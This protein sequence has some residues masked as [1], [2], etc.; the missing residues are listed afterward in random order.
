MKSNSL[1]EVCFAEYQVGLLSFLISTRS[2]VLRL[3]FSPFDLRNA[4]WRTD[5]RYGFRRA[6]LTRLMR[7]GFSGFCKNTVFGKRRSLTGIA[8]PFL[9]LCCIW[10]YR[11]V[12]PIQSIE[13]GSEP[14]VL[15]PV[16][17]KWLRE[18]SL[19]LFASR[20]LGSLLLGFRRTEGWT[21]FR[22]WDYSLF[23]AAKG[24]RISISDPVDAW[25]WGKPCFSVRA[26]SKIL[27]NR[28]QDR[29]LLDRTLSHPGLW[30][31]PGSQG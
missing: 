30:P 29:D 5:Q 6:I 28:A 8:L 17:F 22:D 3:L 4:F 15:I 7:I 25:K 23:S 21:T 24:R 13:L 14:L 19:F 1:P 11:P 20:M 12:G 2:L 9:F 26:N 31:G 10:D 16:Y 27:V 18:R